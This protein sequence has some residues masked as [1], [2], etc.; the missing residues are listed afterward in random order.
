MCCDQTQPKDDGPSTLTLTQFDYAWKWFNFHADQRTKMFNFMLVI[1]GFL[2]AAIANT[3]KG[4]TD[5][6]I[7]VCVIGAILALMFWRLDQRNRQLLTWGEDI[8]ATIERESIYRTLVVKD[9][10]SD[11][12]VVSGILWRQ[13]KEEE[14][15]RNQN[16]STCF[17]ALRAGLRA[18]R[19]GK[20]RYLLP[21]I[22]FVFAVGFAII[23]FW[24][25]FCYH[26]S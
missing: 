24:L 19:M 15:W 14:R 5:L 6:A 23:G 18:I 1:F 3:Y 17:S 7:W 11:G 16:N 12:N 26:A 22:T 9:R 8:L 2:I 25:A 4:A 13:E 10:G 21:L 20:H